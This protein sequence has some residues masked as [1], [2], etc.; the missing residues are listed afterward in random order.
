MVTIR[1]SIPRRVPTRR[2]S[3]TVSIGL[4]ATRE[5]MAVASVRGAT[6]VV[7][8]VR[9]PAGQWENVRSMRS[10]RLRMKARLSGWGRM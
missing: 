2:S 6:A 10:K 9:P 4:L 5:T 7:G 3:L 8:D 1:I